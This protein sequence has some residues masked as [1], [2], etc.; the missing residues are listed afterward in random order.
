M[1]YEDTLS[2]VFVRRNNRFSADVLIGDETHTVHVKNTGRLKELLR[3]GAGVCLQRSSNPNRKTA[4]DLISVFRQGT[5]W[6]NIDSQVPN[7]LVREYL[8]S[9][10]GPFYDLTL[11]KSEYTFGDSRI[12]FYA[13]ATGRKILM[14]V[15]GCTLEKDGIGWFPDAPTL[16]GARHLRELGEACTKGYETYA[17]FVIAVPGVNEVR[18]Y[19]ENDPLFA[20]EM[21]LSEE[22]GMKVIFLPCRTEMD[23]IEII[24][25]KVSIRGRERNG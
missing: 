23:S 11:V 2:A 7:V 24:P 16:R 22:K 18:P 19:A 1:R 4:Y 13:E 21:A 14:E 15:K 10:S 5:G 6:V 25:D 20:D 8:L 3:E 17:A 9:R 12:D